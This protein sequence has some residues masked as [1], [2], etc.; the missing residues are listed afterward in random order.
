MN[1]R[2]IRRWPASL[3]VVAVLILQLLVPTQ[4]ATFPRWV[5]PA[6]GALLLLPLIWMNPFH[7]RRDEPWLRWVELALLAVLV[8]ANTVYLA[9]LIVY[10]NSGDANNGLVLVKSA[11][12]IWDERRRLRRLV[13]GGRPRWSVRPRARA[14]ARRGAGRPAVPA[15]DRRSAGVEQVDSGLHGLSVRGVHRGDRVQPDRHDAADRAGQGA[16]GV[17]VRDRSAH[18]RGGRGPGR[19]RPLR[20]AS[21]VM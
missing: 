3:A 4:I 20:Q 15:D 5:M 9:E 7:L 8:L 11:A 10:L 12:L 13:L 18:D 16:D 1:M 17:P 6:L 19:E 2:H 21:T 14:R